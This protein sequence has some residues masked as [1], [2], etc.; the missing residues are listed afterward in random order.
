MKNTGSTETVVTS[1]VDFFFYKAHR[2]ISLYKEWLLP[3]I[4]MLIKPAEV[5][6][7]TNR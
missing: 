2:A 1:I 4:S 3:T 5:F 7:I 6:N